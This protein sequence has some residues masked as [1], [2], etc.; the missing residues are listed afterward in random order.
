[1]SYIQNL[2]LLKKYLIIRKCITVSTIN[3]IEVA[4]AA[5]II[6]YLGINTIFNMIFSIAENKAIL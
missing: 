3:E 4:I 6:S 1:M 5:P 2:K